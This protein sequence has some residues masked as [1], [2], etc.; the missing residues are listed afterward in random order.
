MHGQ[1]WILD[2]FQGG[3]VTMS[4][5]IQYLKM[6]DVK[7]STYKIDVEKFLGRKDKQERSTLRVLSLDDAASVEISQL[8]RAMYEARK[9]T[10]ITA[11]ATVA[12]TASDAATG[13]QEDGT[14]T[15]TKAVTKND[16]QYEAFK[17]QNDYTKYDG[18]SS[19]QAEQK[20]LADYVAYI[21]A[22][23]EKTDLLRD[24]KSITVT[25]EEPVNV[26][27]QIINF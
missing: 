5:T 21:N 4:N 25:G 27:S 20:E 24:N 19:A 18:L 12:N 11:E 17:A 1:K 13:N 7:P 3:N 10:P 15:A 14:D 6:H 26:N 23:T 22:H 9:A 16:A 8:A 2:I